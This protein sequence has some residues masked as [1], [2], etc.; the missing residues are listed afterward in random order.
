ML[1]VNPGSGCSMFVSGKAGKQDEST[2]NLNQ[3][4]TVHWKSADCYVNG[5]P[6]LHLQ[7]ANV[8]FPCTKITCTTPGDLKWIDMGLDVP[9]GAIITGIIICYQLS[10][11]KSFISQVRLTEQT[12]P[13]LRT[14]H[15]DDSTDLVSTAPVCATSKV[16]YGAAINGAVNLSLRLNFTSTNDTIM[17]GAVGVIY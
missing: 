12:T 14:V 2:I 8:Q 6:T 5:D 4:S 1:R 10:N 15:H 3:M 7:Y 13:N 9:P 16:N 11:S 17:L